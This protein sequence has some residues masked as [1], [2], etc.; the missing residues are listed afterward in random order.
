MGIDRS[1]IG[2]TSAELVFD[3]EKGNIKRW[4]E[5]VGD[6]NPAYFDEETAKKGRY[7]GVIAPPYF[8]ASVVVAVDFPLPL[9]PKRTL[10]AEEE[11]TYYR[12][13]RPGDRLR[14]Q[15]RVVDIYDREGRSGPMTFVVVDTESRDDA[16]NLVVNCRSTLVYR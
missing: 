2:R 8:P 14:C 15:A 9:D 7:G 3:V 5:A 13:I 11:Y 6:D 16:G 10:H 1:N 4:A 12:Q